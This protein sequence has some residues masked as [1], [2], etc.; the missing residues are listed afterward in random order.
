MLKEKGSIS[1]NT[2]RISAQ[3]PAELGEILSKISRA[4]K[5]PKSY[6]IKKA[7][8]LF[9]TSRL[10]D[11]EDYEEAQRSYREFVVSGEKRIPFSEIKK[12]HDL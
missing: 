6:Y 10:E 7:L 11:I 12:K 1:C 9:L 5:M 8:E 3:I 4:E 2:V